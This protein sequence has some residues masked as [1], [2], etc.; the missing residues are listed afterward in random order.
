MRGFRTRNEA[1]E[2]DHDVARFRPLQSLRYDPAIGT[3]GDLVCPPYDVIDATGRAQLQARSPYNAVHLE[4]PDPPYEQV[5]TLIGQWVAAGALRPDARP[6][7]IG[8]TQSFRL[9]DGSEHERRVL[10]ATVEATPYSDRVVR[11]HERTHAGPKEDRL[12]L[13][14][15]AG[16]QISPVYGLYPDAEGAVWAA[17]AV[18]GA[19]DAEFTSSDGTLNRVWWV[20]DPESWAAVASAMADRWILIADGHH[21]YETAV[22]YREERDAAGDGDG[23]H[24]WVMMGLTALD[25][26]GLVVLPT[27]RVLTEWPA[28][29]AEGFDVTPVS[30][31]DELRARLATA[32]AGAPA[33][34]LVTPG[35]TAVLT[36]P[37]DPSASPAARLDVAVL[38][39]RI[40]KPAFGEDQAALTARG[41][42]SYVKDTAEAYELGRRGGAAAVLILRSMPT[43][44]VREVAEAGETMPQ[45]S[46][47]FFPK[48]VTG[49]AFHPLR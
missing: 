32:P 18:A 31:L 47:Y 20:D 33:F 4:L 2:Y 43:D 40:L 24:R 39:E 11:P 23:A 27:H 26:P 34:G 15:G 41:V 12:R 28:G 16:H 17:A 21:R 29:I 7:V 42:L 46:T 8:W 38:E 30:G 25:D 13:L 45:K 37:A 5:G 19:P 35:G 22:R 14:Y 48:L 3:L 10:L 49:L 36:G 44:A 9:D 6:G 1:S